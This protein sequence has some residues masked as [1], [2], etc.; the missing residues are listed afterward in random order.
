MITHDTLMLMKQ[1]QAE[2]QGEEEEVYTI[3]IDP[4][5]ILQFDSGG[6]TLSMAIGGDCPDV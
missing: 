2:K 1:R 4:I 6:I 5:S 3:Y